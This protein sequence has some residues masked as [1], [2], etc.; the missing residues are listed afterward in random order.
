MAAV[1]LADAGGSPVRQEGT[2]VSTLVDAAAA[3]VRAYQKELTSVV[4]DETYKQQVVVQMPR[5]ELQPLKRALRSEIFFMFTVGHDWMAIRDVREV[6]GAALENRPDP[7][8]ALRLL[9][10]PA[11]AGEFKTYNSRFNV[12]RVSRNFNEPTLSLLPLDDRHRARFG[13][14]RTRVRK[15]REGRLVTLTYRERRGPTLVRNLDGSDAFA[16]G[17]VTIE[18]GTGRVTN[19]VLA[20]TMGS[21][22]ATLSTSYALDERLR[23]MVPVRFGEH[24]ED[25]IARPPTKL[26]PRP[27]YEEIRCEAVYANFRRFE[28]TAR[29]R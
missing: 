24:Y 20:V 27:G 2:A 11:V 19:A 29:I 17:E 10:A 12:G 13:F 28:V 16:T 18:P 8:Q 5:D 23:I 14:E 1:P 25:G 21:V 22:R 4:A 15:G 9:P 26:Q 7:R 6:D 3:Y